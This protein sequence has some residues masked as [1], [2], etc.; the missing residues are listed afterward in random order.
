MADVKMTLYDVT[1]QLMANENPMDSI[2]FTRKI[3]EIADDMAKKYCWMLL[4]RERNDYTVFL[5]DDATVKSI[6]KE[7]I[8]T[9]HNRGQ[10]LIM[11]KQPDGAYEIWIRD[12]KT[13]ENFVYYLFDYSKG[14][15]KC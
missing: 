12:P 1:K 14:I 2:A 15:I 11:E 6:S 3:T 13:N 7:M 8:P 4:C 10:V 9:L 5:T